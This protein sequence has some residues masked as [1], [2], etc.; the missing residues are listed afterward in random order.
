LVSG[1]NENPDD[2]AKSNGSGKSSIW[3]AIAWVLTGET[4]RGVKDVV[5]IKTTDGCF[6][7]LLFM[8]DNNEYRILRSK[9]H[10]EYK[11]NLK[12]YINGEDKSGK[13]IRDSEKLLADYIPDLTASLLGSVIILGQGLPERFSN[14]TPSGRKEVLEKLSKSD[15]MIEDLKNKISRRKE[16]LTNEFKV[17]SDSSLSYTSKIEVLKDNLNTYKNKISELG[18]IDKFD[19]IIND[20]SKTIPTHEEEL[21]NNTIKSND[22]GKIVDDC[23]TRYIELQ[24]ECNEELEK[25]LLD[26]NTELNLYTDKL[27]NLNSMCYSLNAEITKLKNIKDTCP[28]CGQKIPN[29]EKPDTTEKENEKKVLDDEIFELKSRINELKN[30]FSSVNEDIKNK[31][32]DQKLNIEQLATS[33][34]NLRKEILDII[35]KEQYELNKL[36]NEF[37]TATINKQQFYDRLEDLNKSI[38]ATT[39]NINEFSE[40]IMYNNMEREKLQKHLDVITKMETIIKRDFRGFLLTNVIDF[41]NKKSKEFSKDI[42]D[43]DKID[44]ILNGNNI[45]IKYD[46]KQYETLSGGEKQ[47]I[48]IIVQLAI[49]EMLCKFLNFS[50]N[51]IVLDEIFDN[52][53]SVGCQRVLNLISNKLSDITSIYIVT[54]HT[55]VSI[56]YDH[57]L[58]VI[59]DK[60]GISKIK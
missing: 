53:D 11:T 21:N 59:K 31:Y 7:E 25:I 35:N 55:D 1:I 4:I 50:S 15:F 45:D 33:N 56:P 52:L 51:I 2:S 16:A 37:N 42:F 34:K 26:Q 46:E 12:I 20:L 13:G 30:K 39:E 14:N 18:T 32:K 40:K 49:R 17:T 27:N 19:D 43:T 28:T 44:F 60:N 48:D 22:L 5:N 9:D 8:L 10:C 6:V 3:E 24:N 57:E 38:N 29:V 23:R 58:I 47:K 36:K 41:I 54:H